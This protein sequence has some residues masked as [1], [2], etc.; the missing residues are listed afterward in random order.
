MFFP[1]PNQKLTSC[2]SD[3]WSCTTW[4]PAVCPYSGATQTRKC[5]KTRNCLTDTEKAGGEEEGRC[6]F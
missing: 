1:N 5:T 6:F 4:D 3:D 2:T